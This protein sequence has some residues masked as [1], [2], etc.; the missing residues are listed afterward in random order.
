MGFNDSYTLKRKKTY[1]TFIIINLRFMKP[2]IDWIDTKYTLM[3]KFAN[4]GG[5][6]GIF[7]Q[8]TGCSLLALLNI[9]IIFFKTICS[10]RQQ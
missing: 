7:A 10:H 3:D 1:D 8:L 4:F 9:C 2:E 5:K 6:F